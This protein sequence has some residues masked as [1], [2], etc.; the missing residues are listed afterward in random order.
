MTA[1]L[2]KLTV[3]RRWRAWCEP[4]QDGYQGAKP[5]AKKWADTHNLHHHLAELTEQ[6]KTTREQWY[7]TE[8]RTDEMIPWDDFSNHEKRQALAYWADLPIEKIEPAATPQ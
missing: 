1:T 7:T 3:P 8:G 2:E 4:C 5:T 6:A